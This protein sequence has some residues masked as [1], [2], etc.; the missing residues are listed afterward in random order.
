MVEPDPRCE[1]AL[2]GGL[3]EAGWAALGE[4]LRRDP[5]MRARW[6][7]A[8]SARAALVQALAEDRG[9]RRHETPLRLRRIALAAGLLLAVGVLA[10]LAWPAPPAAPA[11]P[12]MIVTGGDHLRPS[13]GARF[14]AVDDA[15]TRR[16][17]LE[18]GRLDVSVTRDAQGRG[19]A[20]ETPLLLAEVAGTRFS[21]EASPERTRLEVGEGVVQARAGGDEV[22]VPAGSWVERGTDGWRLAPGLHPWTTLWDAAP[23][24]AGAA[25]LRRGVRT[26]L[27]GSPACA[28]MPGEETPNLRT[29]AIDLP[30]ALDWRGDGDAVVEL[31]YSLT[32]ASEPGHEPRL[33][34]QGW[35]HGP[36]LLTDLPGDRAGQHRH[37]L[38][39][40][41]MK[42]RG[43]GPGARIRS[44]IIHAQP[45]DGLILLG[46]R[47]LDHAPP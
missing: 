4:A 34:L 44:L 47:I 20:I 10:W 21:L 7:A 12:A 19:F 33:L 24:I 2:D 35:D 38:P 11:P 25:P 42:R 41:G 45:A 16:W 15:L 26:A 30:D 9:L 22:M 28:G 1:A 18:A 8:A 39:V 14:A 17:R 27:A 36:A 6:W 32:A 31:R 37:R 29:I 13:A 3:D 40:A 5:E 43:D 23:H 46:A